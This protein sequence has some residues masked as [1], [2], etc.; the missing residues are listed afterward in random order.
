MKKTLMGLLAV[1]VL[2]GVSFAGGGSKRSIE[3]TVELRNTTYGSAEQKGTTGP[4]NGG[5][6]TS[7][8]TFGKHETTQ[9]NA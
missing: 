1:T 6:T 9:P 4:G 3:E 8:W 5:Y 7:G 2:G